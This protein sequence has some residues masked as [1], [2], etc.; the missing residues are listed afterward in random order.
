VV[1]AAAAVAGAM[2]TLVEWRDLVPADSYPNLAGTV[3]GVVCATL[4]ALI[5]RLVRNRIGWMLLSEEFGLS[6]MCLTSVYAVVG[7]VTHPD[8]LRGRGSSAPRRPVAWFSQRRSPTRSLRS[9]LDRSSVR[10]VQDQHVE[11]A[12]LFMSLDGS[13]MAAEPARPLLQ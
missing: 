12:R 3:A 11:I 9:L 8:V 7:I 6:H 1:W 13:S 4:G 10:S 2:L 5:V